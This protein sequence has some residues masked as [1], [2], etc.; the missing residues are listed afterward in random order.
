MRRAALPV[1]AIA[2]LAA[3]SVAAAA[4]SGGGI[5]PA[6]FEV[7]RRLQQLQDGIAEGDAIAQ[8]AH[9]KA[10][11]HT[12][13]LFVRAPLATWSD[14]RNAR[15]LVVYLFS[16]GSGPA[17]AEVVAPSALA[18]PYRALY[19][20]ALA[21]SLGDDE[22]ARSVLMPI[23]AKTL[24]TGVGGHLALVQATLCSDQDRAK[25]FALLDLARLLEPGT[26]IEEAALRKEM[27]LIGATGDL[28]KF[29]LLARRYLGAF[30]HSVY[31]DNFRQLVAA[32]AMKISTSDS[33]EAGLRLTRLAGTLDKADQRRLYL[34]I[35]RAAVVAGHFKMAA[36][37]AAAAG[38][39][40][41]P[42]GTD[43]ARAMTYLGAATIVGD[44]YEFGRRTLEKVVPDRL[45][46]RD[47]ALRT[48]AV[49]VAD[50]I[51]KPPA[52]GD[53]GP[54]ETNQSDIVANGERLLVAADDLLNKASK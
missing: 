37:A 49:A 9:A 43:E 28:D 34:A 48:S 11:E 40:S 4:G 7:V 17:I 5:D 1:L 29:G 22:T 25:A 46:I 36:L 39:R 12:A 45:G 16:G 51:R 14:P 3:M 42:A 33:D 35:A 50:L 47:R 20:G 53:A 24:S 26:L 8:A 52:A 2:A 54:T 23:D 13:R 10:I 32:T 6:P 44:R 31:A 38:E 18:Q 19:M 41:D 27:S 30:G 15:A 21:Y